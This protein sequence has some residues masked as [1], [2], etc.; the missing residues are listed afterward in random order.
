MGDRNLVG[1]AGDDTSLLCSPAAANSEN[2]TTLPRRLGDILNVVGMRD[3]GGAEPSGDEL[4][5][6]PVD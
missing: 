4:S 5:N 2:E 6:D 3:T 1:D